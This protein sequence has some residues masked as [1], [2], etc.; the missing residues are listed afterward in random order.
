MRGAL[1][2]CY[3]R[4]APAPEADPTGRGLQVASARFRAHM[5]ILA[6]RFTVVPLE[7]LVAR[8][9][10]GARTD[11][12]AAVTF[13][14]GYADNYL[15]AF[16]ILSELSIPATIFLTTDYIDRARPFWMERLARFVSGHLGDVV[17]LPAEIGGRVDLTS[18][19]DAPRAYQQLRARLQELDDGAQRERWLDLL[20]AGAPPDS[21]PLTWDEIRTMQRGGVAFGAHT[22]THPSLPAV[23][24]AALR[25][26]IDASREMITARLAHRPAVF[27]Y[28]FGDVDERVRAAVA[29]A[30]FRAAVT[31]RGG[32]CG[33]RPAP[34]LLPRAAVAD[35]TA[36]EFTRVLDA[37]G[38]V[39]QRI[40]AFAATLKTKV[41]R[42]VAAVLKRTPPWRSRSG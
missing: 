10:D 9:A 13:D 28:P 27:A 22:L 24:N 33:T 15:S 29:A 36:E 16:P 32:R 1:V 23:S 8:L 39:P 26:E 3:H 38:T 2:L 31:I 5:E 14:D 6:R 41:P 25:L 30:G 35:W 4:V 17:T 40:R 7:D 21:R 11:G 19:A 18:T 37:L 12:M 20:G 34:L 42:P